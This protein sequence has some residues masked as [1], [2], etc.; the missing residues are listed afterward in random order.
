MSGARAEPILR[1]IQQEKQENCSSNNNMDNTIKKRTQQPTEKKTVGHPTKCPVQR[2]GKIKDKNQPTPD[3][4][5]RPTK[6]PVQCLY[7]I[8]QCIE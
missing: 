4:F 1:Q 5:G 7:L 8:T 6:C 2:I 3:N